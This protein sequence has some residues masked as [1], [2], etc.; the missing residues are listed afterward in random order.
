M[1]R[2]LLVAFATSLMLSSCSK[3]FYQ[4]YNTETSGLVEKG[5]AL[6]YE[7]DDCELVYNLW[8]E[9]GNIGFIIKNKT[10]D[11]L[12][13]FMP[14]TFFVKNDMAFDY[15]K[16]RE[17]RKAESMNE[18]SGASVGASVF[19]LAS[20]WNG[21]Y[22]A[23]KSASLNAGKTRG[24]SYTLVT[25]ESPIVCIPAHSLKII[26]EYS[27]SNKLFLNCN[28]KQDFPKNKSM[29]LTYSKE[30]SPLKFKNRIAYSFSKDGSALKYVENEFW[31]SGLINY[32]AKEAGYKKKVKECYEE[33]ETE[34]YTFKVASP[35][36]FYNSY[37]AK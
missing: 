20:L 23:S 14:Q 7:N 30:D 16:N 32:S 28:K 26:S 13:V 37:R 9:D 17:Y 27:I 12:F 25:K 19:G 35:N 3:T 6:I 33:Y 31:V 2:L 5:D 29:P 4:V 11:D 18:S 24:V 15:F 21:V 10:D 8:A 22:D 1:T 36:K 34:V